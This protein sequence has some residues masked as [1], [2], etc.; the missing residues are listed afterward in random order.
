MASD[1]SSAP[2]PQAPAARWKTSLRGLRGALR[3][4]LVTL[5]IVGGFPLVLL[6]RVLLSAA[7]RAQARFT[8]RFFRGW[9]GII[10]ALLRIRVHTSGVAPEPPFLLVANHLS[11]LDV[12]VLASRLPCVFVSKAEVQG[13]PLLGPICTSLGTIYIDRGQRREIPRVL[14]A[15]EAAL[16]RGLGVVFF[17]EGTSSK[18]ETVAPF[19]SPL[20]ELPVR[21]GRAVHHATLGYR[22]LPGEPPA[23]DAVCFWGSAHFAS[24]AWGIL[25]LR[26]VAA[27]LH[28]DPEPI[29]EA[30]RKILAERLRQA[31]LEH[32]LPTAPY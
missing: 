2:L 3:L 14:A 23:H 6:G 28:L 12:L 10:L 24:H 21:L 11:Y 29:T 19:K 31:I 15:I 5:L 25:G 18:G 20:L 1:P 4:P 13:W 30:D 16:D 22:T 17:P 27:T 9:A 26:G 7:P 8:S 32:F